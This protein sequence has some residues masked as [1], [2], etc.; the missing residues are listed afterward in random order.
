MVSSA[1]GSALIPPPAGRHASPQKRQHAFILHRTGP[2]P[3]TLDD[4][5]SLE[6][7]KRDFGWGSVI[8]AAGASGKK[9]GVKRRRGGVAVPPTTAAPEPASTHSSVGASAAGRTASRSTTDSDAPTGAAAG[10]NPDAMQRV[11]ASIT[12][13]HVGYDARKAVFQ[14]F[15]KEPTTN[16][17]QEITAQT[18]F[19]AAL[20]REIYLVEV[21]GKTPASHPTEPWLMC[22]RIALAHWV[23]PGKRAHTF[24]WAGPRP[25]DLAND[26]HEHNVLS[27]WKHTAR[28]VSSSSS[29]TQG[30]QNKLAAARAAG[31]ASAAQRA[32]EL[33]ADGTLER[34]EAERRQDKEQ[35][36]AEASA[37]ADDAASVALASRDPLVGD[38]TGLP[39]PSTNALQEDDTEWAETR[40]PGVKWQRTAMCWRVSAKAPGKRTMVI[41]ASS[42]CMAALLHDHQLACLWRMPP[43]SGKKK[44]DHPSIKWYYIDRPEFKHF[45]LH[46]PGQPPRW[47]GPDP[48]HMSRHTT[49]SWLQM[50]FSVTGVRGRQLHARNLAALAQAQADDAGPASS[51][52]C[53]L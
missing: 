3:W 44:G 2:D 7:L 20:T 35:R 38:M 30:T 10:H 5:C 14:C 36:A 42:A 4:T 8:A 29:G 17:P 32:A 46:L 18:P 47:V 11:L 37:A 33:I 21:V 16:K 23:Q 28:A 51:N 40:F 13:E 9:A 50:T 1:C 53:D 48:E 52:D 6:E 34:M 31:G 41:N 24:R 39:N 15:V 22:N 19:L 12:Y 26:C 45:V 43:G 27:L 49:D 25:E